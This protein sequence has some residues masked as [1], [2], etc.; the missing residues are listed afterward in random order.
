MNGGNEVLDLHA[1]MCLVKRYRLGVK[2]SG[3]GA[4]FN[5]SNTWLSPP[6]SEHLETTSTSRPYRCE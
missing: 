3:L 4:E 6:S 5:K 2:E 1:V